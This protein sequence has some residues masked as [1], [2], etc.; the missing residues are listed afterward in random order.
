[1]PSVRAQAERL[2]INRNTVNRAYGELLRE[3]VL[4]SEPGRG[5]FVAAKQSVFKR[6]E[7]L[8]RVKPALNEF[9]NEALALQFSG[10]EMLKLVEDR[11]VELDLVEENETGG[12]A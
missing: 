1:M 2:L 3:G 9:V 10:D 11:L 12:Y 4:R 7:R 6:S 8:R 5:L